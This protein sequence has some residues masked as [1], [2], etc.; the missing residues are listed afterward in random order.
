M[1]VGA[2]SFGSNLRSG[3]RQSDL[4]LFRAGNWLFGN[5]LL[6]SYRNSKNEK[7][8]SKIKISE[9][10]TNRSQLALGNRIS[11]LANTF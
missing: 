4:V 2:V 9:S 1:R 7:C 11:V 6:G 8:I 10:P 3:C 5:R